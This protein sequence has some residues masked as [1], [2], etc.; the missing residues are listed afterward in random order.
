MICR[1]RSADRGSDVKQKTKNGPERIHFR[2]RLKLHNL[3]TLLFSLILIS[4][5]DS[6]INR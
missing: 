5:F 3:Q 2:G 1:H 4:S 6:Y